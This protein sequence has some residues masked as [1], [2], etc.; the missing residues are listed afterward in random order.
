M[1]EHTRSLIIQA[2]RSD[3][4]TMT[5]LIETLDRPILQVLIEAHIVETSKDTAMELGIQWG[6]L[7]HHSD[8]NSNYWI[9]PDANQQVEGSDTEI[10]PGSG[11]V[12]NFPSTL[13]EGVG[14][15]IG[16]VAQKVGRYL[17]SAQLSALQKQGRLN[18]LS[19]PSVTTLDN[20]L[21]TIESGKDVPFQTVEDGEVDIVFKKAVLSLEVTPHVIDEQTL[22]MSIRTHK[23]ELDFSKPVQGNPTIITK[24][25]ETNVILFD[26]QTTVIGGLSKETSSDS[27]SGVP[28]LKDIP[29][30]GNLFKGKGSQNNMEEVLIFITPHILRERH[31]T[32]ET[33]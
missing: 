18:I 10:S 13:E 19:S 11:S 26:G 15:N 8:G 27:E 7:Y 22:K 17:L 25:A 1:N 28:V 9:T 12:V 3:I 5:A 24:N 32:H 33:E 29:L 6:G 20:Q 30:L 21:A 2:T 31:L 4:E 16:Y 14:L 23:D